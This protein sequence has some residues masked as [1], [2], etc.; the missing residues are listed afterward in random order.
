M[1]LSLRL[2]AGLLTTKLIVGPYLMDNPLVL[3]LYDL[4]SMLQKFFLLLVQLID[5]N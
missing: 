4:T 1:R 3:P 5:F 2:L